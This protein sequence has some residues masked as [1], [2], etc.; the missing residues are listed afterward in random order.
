MKFVQ[1]VT[2]KSEI[3][4]SSSVAATKGG[5]STIV[6]HVPITNRIS[7]PWKDPILIPLELRLDATR[8]NLYRHTGSRSAF[9]RYVARFEAR[10]NICASLHIA[11]EALYAVRYS[12]EGTV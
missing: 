2:I 6:L 10:H 8:S 1:A 11:A 7:E 12:A 9:V 5:L 3:L 4:I